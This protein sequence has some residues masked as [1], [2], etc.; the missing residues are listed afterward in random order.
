MHWHN[1]QNLRE[2]LRTLKKKKKKIK[3]QRIY[4]YEIIL[5]PCHF[6]KMNVTN[7]EG[8]RESRESKRP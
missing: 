3:L 7:G 4:D 6:S 2:K 8:E 5:A 1:G